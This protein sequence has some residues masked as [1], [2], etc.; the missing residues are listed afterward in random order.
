MCLLSVEMCVRD[1]V[2]W[3]YVVCDAP[4]FVMIAIPPCA[5]VNEPELNFEINEPELNFATRRV[6][7][8][9]CRRPSGR[10]G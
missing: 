6:R 2:V 7:A 4:L 3:H 9:F 8:E 5:R 10:R 1:M